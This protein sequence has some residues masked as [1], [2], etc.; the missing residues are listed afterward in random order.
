MSEKMEKTCETCVIFKE[1]AGCGIDE[2]Y[3]EFP[4][5]YTCKHHTTLQE[6][7]AAQKMKKWIENAIWHIYAC[8]I[9]DVISYSGEE[10]IKEAKEILNEME[11]AH[12]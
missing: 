1:Y 4:E 5:D 9:K 10:L 7:L 8:N 6:A 12:E 3:N 11:S 2:H